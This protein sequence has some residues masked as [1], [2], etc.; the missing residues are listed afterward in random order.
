MGRNV[1]IKQISRFWFN[2][3][4]TCVRYIR[5]GQPSTSSRWLPLFFA[6]AKV[7]SRKNAMKRSLTAWLVLIGLTWALSSV[8]E[9][10]HYYNPHD[11]LCPPQGGHGHGQGSGFSLSSLKNWGLS[12]VGEAFHHSED[13]TFAQY[14]DYNYVPGPS[15][16]TG[17]LFAPIDVSPYGSGP[18]HNE[19]FFGSYEYLYYS[20]SAPDDVRIGQTAGTVG[21]FIFFDSEFS[22]GPMETL[23]R[24]GS[25]AELGWMRKNRGW[26]FGGAAYGAYNQEVFGAGTNFHPPPFVAVFDLSAAQTPIPIYDLVGYNE[27][28]TYSAEAMRIWRLR[29]PRPQLAWDPTIEV[30]AGVRYMRMRD[31]FFLR[32][33]VHTGVVNTQFTDEP[34]DPNEL[35][36]EQQTYSIESENNLVGPQIGFRYEQER[37]PLSYDL[38]GRAMAAF[39]FRTFSTDSNFKGQYSDTNPPPLPPFIGRIQDEDHDV[40]FLPVVEFRVNAKY[41]VTRLIKLGAGW[42]MVYLGDGIGRST[43]AIDWNTLELFN[44]V[45]TQDVFFHGFNLMVEVNR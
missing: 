2:L 37:G 39:N 8:A 38:S 13:S 35:F 23:F 3:C 45:G 4:H 34:F 31:D 26:L 32:A 6:K 44:N 36:R 7:G 18:K 28:E 27:T 24:D 25:R 16:D 1:Q 40:E 33:E 9:A 29:R 17:M 30:M 21:D 5:Q 20:M 10:Q 41:Q 22:T 43:D 19:G 42:S 15:F 14:P 12:G 11:P